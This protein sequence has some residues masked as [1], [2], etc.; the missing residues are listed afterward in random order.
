MSTAIFDTDAWI[1][2]LADTGGEI[3][4]AQ[5]RCTTR[6]DFARIGGRKKKG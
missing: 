5:A 6:W 4:K 2:I 3:T 1:S